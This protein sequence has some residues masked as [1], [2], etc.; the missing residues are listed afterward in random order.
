MG[1]AIGLVVAG[2]LAIWALQSLFARALVLVLTLISLCLIGPIMA[3]PLGSMDKGFMQQP[4]EKLK[5][6]GLGFGI[7]SILGLV[8]LYNFGKRR[9]R[10]GFARPIDDELLENEGSGPGDGESC[11]SSY[12]EV[13][14]AVF[15]IPYNSPEPWGKPG[16]QLP[17]YYVPLRTLA[18][19]LWL[20]LGSSKLHEASLRTI[21]SRADLRWGKNKQGV[22]RLLHPH[23]VCLAGTWRI[24]KD[25]GFSGYFESGKQC[26]IIARYS[27]EQRL[28]SRPRTL[29]LVGKL[30]PTSNPDEKVPTAN[31]ITQ[32]AL[33]GIRKESVFG[34]SLTNAPDLFPLT[35]AM[36]FVRLLLS[37]RA[38]KD[39]DTH[40]TERQ[41]YEIAEAGENV[42]APG[43]QTRSP[44]YMRLTPTDAPV[45]RGRLTD[46]FRDEILS[47]VYNPGVPDRQRTIRFKIE[48][49][50]TGELRGFINRRLVDTSWDEIGEIEFTEAAASYN[51]DFVIHFHHPKWREDLLP[52][53]PKM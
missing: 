48:V 13:H 37:L 19:G 38:F 12:R 46:D 11:E 5:R 30:F 43:W 28:R 47:Q 29:S 36:G 40:K 2:G 4:Y 23:G 44:R 1:L 33:G 16:T 41:L 8:A 21:S 32:S 51:G 18:K 50:S 34:T 53:A 42:A 24:T 39:V 45:A 25:L 31:F 27:S 14:D 20:R 3:A 10:A 17:R 22:Q 49:S 9:G 26:P 7:A 15:G 35:S 6:A 52:V